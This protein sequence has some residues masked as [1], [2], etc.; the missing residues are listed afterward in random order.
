[1]VQL[2]IRIAHV[3]PVKAAGVKVVDVLSQHGKTFIDP[4][5]F[6]FIL[7]PVDHVLEFMRQG[8]VSVA[9]IEFD[10]VRIQQKHLVGVE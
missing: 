6:V 7:I 8:S 9:F 5:F 10:R 2:Q 4:G 1:M 3:V